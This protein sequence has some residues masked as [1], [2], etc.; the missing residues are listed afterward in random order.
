MQ[1]ISFCANTEHITGNDTTSHTGKK[2]LPNIFEKVLFTNNLLT[3]IY[4]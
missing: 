2:E 3:V 1:V 4:Q